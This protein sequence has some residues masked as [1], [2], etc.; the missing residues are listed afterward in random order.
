MMSKMVPTGHDVK[1]LAGGASF[2]DLNVLSLLM[3][4]KFIK[5]HT[6]MRAKR[7]NLKT[8]L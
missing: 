7:V 3:N 8:Y 5:L 4:D 2:N 6:D 1:P